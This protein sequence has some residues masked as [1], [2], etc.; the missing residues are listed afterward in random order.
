MYLKCSY[1]N[2]LT[3]Q[4]LAPRGIYFFKQ[5]H[6]LLWHIINHQL[7]PSVKHF[8]GLDEI[9]HAQQHAAPIDIYKYIYIYT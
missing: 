3:L 2:T 9:K 6:L 4:S 7:D 1:K 5:C 8:V